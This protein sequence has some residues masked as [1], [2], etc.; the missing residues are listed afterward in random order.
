MGFVVTLV[1]RDCRS[2]R[3]EF[4]TSTA[5]L[6]QFTPVERLSSFRLADPYAGP[7]S[8]RRAQLHAHTSNSPDVREKVPV[9]ETVR[10]YREDGYS[11]LVLTDHDRVTGVAGL[12]SPEL[13]V[14]AGVEETVPAPVWP[15][16]RHLL[17]LGVG[18]DGGE[19]LAPAHPAW[20]GNLGTGRWRL[21]DLLARNDYRLF[22]VFNGRSD[23]R[24]DFWLWHQVLARRGW[25]DPVWGIAV[26]DAD[27]AVAMNAG[28][29]MVKVTELTR[30]ALLTA[31]REGRFYATTGPA[32]EFGVVAGAVQA[33]AAGAGWIRFL[34][35]RYDV[36][37]A[38]RGEHG[39]YRPVGDEGF[40]RVEVV[41]GDGHPAWSQPF[42][43]VPEER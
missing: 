33:T 10:R 27:N 4:H 39:E 19:L 30:E 34:N 6:A 38:F 20:E 13:L 37:A 42:F 21:P 26:D 16:G 31:L 35:A 1:A 3:E 17:R 23:S 25:R 8:Y 12:S 40:V 24:R 15:L 2:L 43:L 9:A 7:G 11:F 28:W 14:V 36:V 41:S 32:C 29:V 22:E 18:A 5:L